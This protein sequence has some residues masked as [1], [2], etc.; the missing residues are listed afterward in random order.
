MSVYAIRKEPLSDPRWG[1]DV[2]GHRHRSRAAAERC[3]AAEW[4]LRERLGW[5]TPD[6]EDGES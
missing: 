4:R 2:C 6:A 5:Y 3:E 1:T